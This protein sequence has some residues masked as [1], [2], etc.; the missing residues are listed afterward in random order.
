MVCFIDIGASQMQVSIQEFKYGATGGIQ[1]QEIGYAW[2]DRV[3]SYSVDA[4]LGRVIRREVLKQKPDAV[5][6]D[7]AVQRI[8]AAARKV[9]HELTLQP[10]VTL[11]LEDLV[12]GFDMSFTYS[13]D[14]LKRLC[15]REL[16]VL[17]ATFFEALHGALLEEPEDID[18]FELVGGGTRSPLFQDAI[19]G[20]FNGKVPVMRSLNTEEASVLGAGYHVAAS[21]KGFLAHEMKFT[22][23][24]IY[25]ITVSTGRYTTFSYAQGTKLP[26]GI[27]AFIRTVDLRQTG[28]YHLVDGRVRV[29]G[30]KKLTRSGLHKERRVQVEQTL[31]AFETMEKA[32]AE[33]AKVLHEF[34]STLLEARDKVT[35]DPIVLEIASSEE[36]MEALR[37]I[38]NVQYQVGKDRNI[39]DEELERLKA[40]VE[41]A[42]SRLLKRAQEKKDTPMAYEKLKDFLHKVTVAVET[43]WPRVGMRPKSKPFKVLGRMCA[44]TDRWL[45]E[46][47]DLNEV[48][49]HD[50]NLMFEKLRSAFENVKK[51]LK[52][53]KSSAEL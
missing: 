52:K 22:T 46:H 49:I 7:R 33:K 1:I 51:T 42:T 43:D 17:N 4:A 11:Y 38:A 34:E 2:T 3:G 27:G 53:A 10:E 19:N 9:K 20:F 30:A 36:R 15:R 40:D 39:D 37:V 32:A 48:S 29:R 50:I 24:D 8:I 23:L 25:N 18:R 45:K 12:R 41:R 6:D 14:R 13:I 5:F 16:A 26:L 28:Q 47:T 31:H 21:R 44:K 35:K